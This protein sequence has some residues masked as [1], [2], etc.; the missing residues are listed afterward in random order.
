MKLTS[1]PH[2]AKV[3]TLETIRTSKDSP[4]VPVRT[5]VGD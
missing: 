1:T 5:D 2:V 3:Q 4:G